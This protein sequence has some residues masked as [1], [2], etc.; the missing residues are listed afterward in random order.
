MKLPNN[1]RGIVQID[2]C[3]LMSSQNGEILKN[4]EMLYRKSPLV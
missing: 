1:E 4:D 2:C 3:K